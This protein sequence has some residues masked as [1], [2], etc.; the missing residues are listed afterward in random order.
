MQNIKKLF[1]KSLLVK[2]SY[3]IIGLLICWYIFNQVSNTF[4]RINKSWAEIQFSYEHTSIVRS[5]RE[6]YAS[7]SAE[8]E[9]SYKQKDPT[10]QEKLLE[11]LTE[12]LEGK[13]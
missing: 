7:K 13:K 6:D 8:L 11:E 4:S 12:Q 3:L 9:D 5:V 1:S 2:G 10:V